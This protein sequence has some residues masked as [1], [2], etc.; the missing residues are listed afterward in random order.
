MSRTTAHNPLKMFFDDD[1]LLV[2]NYKRNCNIKDS[3]RAKCDRRKLRHAPID[4]DGVELVNAMAEYKRDI[5]A[6]DRYW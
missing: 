2:G 4:E 1:G 5:F 3:Y 6:R